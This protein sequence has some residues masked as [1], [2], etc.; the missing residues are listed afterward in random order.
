M[1]YLSNIKNSSSTNSVN[2]GLYICI[3]TDVAYIIYYITGKIYS[4]IY[5]PI[6][7]MLKK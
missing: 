2:V 7:Y 3:F 1:F 5:N 4:T 6:K